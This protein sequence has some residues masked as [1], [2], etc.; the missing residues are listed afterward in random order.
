M[1]SLNALIVDDSA[2]MR[3]MIIKTLRLSGLPLQDVLEASNGKEGLT[4][5]D[6]HWVDFIL[7]DINMPVMNGEE[8]IN[9]LRS[10]P[11]TRD[12]PVI[13]VSTE[14]SRGRQERL[15]TKVSRFLTKPFTPESLRQT[16]CEVTG[17]GVAS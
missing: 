4:A 1:P 17:V 6:Q 9:R 15:K 3:A 2:M 13:V 14:S 16:V 5:L 8:M 12:I 11:I 10:N 7:A